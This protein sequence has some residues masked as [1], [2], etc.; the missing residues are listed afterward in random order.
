MASLSLLAFLAA[1]APPQQGGA[2]SATTGQGGSARQ[3]TREP[4]SGTIARL[5]A[6]AAGFMRSGQVK[7]YEAQ[8]PGFG[9]GVE[10]TTPGREAV[11]T[12]DI[13]DRGMA[14]IPNQEQ[15]VRSELDEA[16]RELSSLQHSRTGRSLDE[17][18]RTTIPI[19]GADPLQCAVLSGRYGRVPVSLDICVG[20]AA[21]RFIKIQVT[22]PD[23]TPAMADARAFAH[24]VATAAQRR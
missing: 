12:V 23:R 6:D 16:V 3:M 9:Q 18:Q 13:Y 17:Q 24:S 7:D 4:T 10:Y 11:A 22:M 14:S 15:L 8:R 20:M 19:E 2:P 1:C 21:G 5:P